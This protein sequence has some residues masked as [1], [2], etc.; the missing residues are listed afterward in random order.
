MPRIVSRYGI[1]G[2]FKRDIDAVALLQP[3]D[4]DLDVLL[5]AAGQQELAGSAG[6]GRSAAT[7]LLPGCGGRALPMRSSSL[8]D[9]AS[10]AKAMEGS[11]SLTGG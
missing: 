1:L 5:A 10:M 3:A 6:R 11:G 7:G 8:R 2:A 9:L 4:D